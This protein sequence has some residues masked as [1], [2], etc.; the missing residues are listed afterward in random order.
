M[1]AVLTWSV[2]VGVLAFLILI[3]SKGPLMGEMFV[4]ML[5]IAAMVIL[6]PIIR[7]SKARKDLKEGF[8]LVDERG[9]FIKRKAGYYSYLVT[10]YVILAFMY[11][12][13]F[14]VELFDAPSLTPTV[15][16]ALI[17]LVVLA[18]FG[19]LY[20]WFARRGDAGSGV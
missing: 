10:I 15:Y 3:I 13:L 11:Y 20:L 14:L 5:V 1:L 7:M 16:F 2:V 8:P 9:T 4:L 17:E 19:G 12:E 6:I 18:V